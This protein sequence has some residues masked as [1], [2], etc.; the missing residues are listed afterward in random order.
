MPIIFSSLFLE[1]C[2]AFIRSWPDEN[3]FLEKDFFTGRWN[4]LDAGGE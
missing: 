4:V 1:E 2:T 3:F